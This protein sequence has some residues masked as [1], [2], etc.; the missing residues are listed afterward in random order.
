M[1]KETS[2][3]N[4]IYSAMGMLVEGYLTYQK[5]KGMIRGETPAIREKVM[6]D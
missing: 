6:V 5:I 1:H 3:R 4:L 2:S